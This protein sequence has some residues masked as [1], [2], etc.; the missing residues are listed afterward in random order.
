MYTN[1]HTDSYLPRYKDGGT[2]KN[3]LSLSLSLSV[4]LSLTHTQEQKGD[5][6]SNRNTERDAKRE[7]YHI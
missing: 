1:K 5:V 7:G 6:E 4:S 2:G 3:S